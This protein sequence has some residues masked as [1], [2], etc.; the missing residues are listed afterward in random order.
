VEL[1]GQ[2]VSQ[3]NGMNA[4]D[5]TEQGFIQFCAAL[6][7]RHG[8]AEA[9]LGLQDERGWNVNCLLLSAWAARLGFVL[10]PEF[11]LEARKAIEMLD[12]EA[13]APIRRVRRAISRNRKFNDELKSGIRRLLWYAELRAE[14]AVETTLHRTMVARAGRGESCVAGNL[15]AYAGEDSPVVQRLAALFSESMS[16]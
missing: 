9:C 4:Y 2:A 7:Q 1:R 10:T 12:S 3:A 8:V 6:Y 11:W 5:Q 15:A 13:V 16:H 14:Q